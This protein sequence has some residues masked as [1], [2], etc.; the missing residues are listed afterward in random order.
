MVTVPDGVRELCDSCFRDCWRL[1]HVTVGPSS[2]L[3][4]VGALCFYKCGLV[5]FEIPATVRA[6]GGGAFSECRLRGGIVCRD[7]CCFRAI[8][9][10][11]LS[12]D[13]TRCFSRYG[14]LSSVSVPD[15][16]R[17][18][19]DGCFRGCS[20]LRHV[21]FG[22]CSSLERI[23]VS[24][25]QG[26]GVEEFVVPDGVHELCDYCFKWCSSLRHVT[27][28]PSSSLE[29]IGAACFQRSGVKEV[30]VPDSVRELCDGCL[31]NSSLRLVTF[32]PSSSLERIGVEAFGAMRDLEGTS[33]PC[34]LE[35]ITIPDS[36]RE[37]CDRCFRG[38]SSLRRVTFGPSS[39]LK[40]I[41]V[42]C[43]EKSGVVEV[44]VPDGVQL[45]ENCFRKCG[46]AP[47]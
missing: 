20:S 25:F 34:G 5:E 2:T 11:V 17:E 30:S 13:C 1:Q 19:C 8:D 27:F 18:L 28:G 31:R 21:T 10:L 43:F 47:G 14:D 40:R 44:A 36:V 24:C 3:E 15:S 37:L 45:G 38:C 9:G 23:G 4:R 46:L 26:T 33:T 12:G 35:E 22:P 29:R 7:G 16:V 41:G 39:S 42:S 6:I 32:G